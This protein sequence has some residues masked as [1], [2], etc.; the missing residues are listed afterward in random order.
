MWHSEEHVCEI[1]ASTIQL[2]VTEPK[3]QQ[4]T[5][6][7]ESTLSWKYAADK[8]SRRLEARGSVGHVHY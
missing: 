4:V 7:S 5:L 6:N 2:I 8:T 3:K 1:N